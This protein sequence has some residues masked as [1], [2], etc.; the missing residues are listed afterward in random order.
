MKKAFSA[1][2]NF[3][4]AVLLVGQALPALGQLKAAAPWNAEGFAFQISAPASPGHNRAFLGDSGSAGDL[5]N[6]IRNGRGSRDRDC[7]FRLRKDKKQAPALWSWGPEIVGVDLAFEARLLEPL[8]FLSSRAR[9]KLAALKPETRA[10]N[11]FRRSRDRPLGA[12][13]FVETDSISGAKR[14]LEAF[15]V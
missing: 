14:P 12:A 10:L 3:V 4:L 1:T 8:C 7:G 9:L 15:R 5:K 6:V 13:S 11:S 2:I